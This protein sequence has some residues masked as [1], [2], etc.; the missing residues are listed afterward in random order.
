MTPDT[1]AG[2]VTHY[3]PEEHDQPECDADV[4][5]DPET[6]MFGTLNRNKVTCPDCLHLMED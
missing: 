3:T 1:G 2:A 5:A 6:V 4:D